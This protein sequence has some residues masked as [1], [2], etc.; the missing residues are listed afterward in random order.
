MAKAEN[1]QITPDT[2]VKQPAGFG[3]ALAHQGDFA[4]DAKPEDAKKKEDETATNE[5]A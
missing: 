1:K 5:P 3:A 2:D 4:G